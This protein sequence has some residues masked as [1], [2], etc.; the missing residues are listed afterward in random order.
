MLKLTFDHLGKNICSFFKIDGNNTSKNNWNCGS[1]MLEKF[2]DRAQISWPFIIF[3]FSFSDFYHVQSGSCG[4]GALN[5]SKWA[6]VQRIQQHFW[7]VL[8]YGFFFALSFNLHLWIVQRTE[9][10]D[11][12]FWKCPWAP[13]VIYRRESCLFIYHCCLIAHKSQASSCTLWPFIKGQIPQNS[14][15]LLIS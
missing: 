8:A 11:R 7:I 13:S 4:G 10:T 1:K 6:L 15:N 9:F 5:R 14:S 3:F 12:D 2:V